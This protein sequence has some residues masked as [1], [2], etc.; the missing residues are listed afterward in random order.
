[1]ETNNEVFPPPLSRVVN[2]IKRL[3]VVRFALRSSLTS[4]KPLLNP[5]SS[6][7]CVDA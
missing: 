2:I 7:Y 6:A 3:W 5:V 4:Q 1:M